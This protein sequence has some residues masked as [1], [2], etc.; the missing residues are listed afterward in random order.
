[1]LAV[2]LCSTLPTAQNAFIYAQQYGLDTRVVRNS[3]VASTVVSMAT[4]SLASW[5]LGATP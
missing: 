1:M 2:V 4:L 5:A 3:V